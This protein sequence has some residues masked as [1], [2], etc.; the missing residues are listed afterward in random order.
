MA[1]IFQDL[2]VTAERNGNFEA[3]DQDAWFLTPCS[4]CGGSQMAV[5]AITKDRATAWLRCVACSTGHVRNRDAVSPSVMPL[6]DPVGVPDVELNTWREVRKCL[7]IRANTAA[8]MM[9]RKILLHV[10]VAQGLPA[11]NSKGRA[12]SFTDAVKYLE[13]EEVITKRMRKWVKKIKDVGNDANHEIMPV[14]AEQALDV[15]TFTEQ[16]LRLAYELDALSG[17]GE[18]VD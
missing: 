2:R 4:V 13:D 3:S 5:I 9:C 15:A 8:V 6:R 16:L 14:T 1:S 7:G 11:Q 12:P 17:G 10:A 18:S